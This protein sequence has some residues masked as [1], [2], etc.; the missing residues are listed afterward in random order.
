MSLILNNRLQII[1]AFLQMLA[2]HWTPPRDI[3]DA[4]FCVIEC[5][6]SPLWTAPRESLL[7]TIPFAKNKEKLIIS[8]LRT[9][10]RFRLRLYCFYGNIRGPPSD[11]FYASTRTGIKAIV[12]YEINSGFGLFMESKPDVFMIP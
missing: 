9:D 10:T 12:I 1:H 2:I 3:N 5:K 7:I 4:D 6:D 11:W 8:G